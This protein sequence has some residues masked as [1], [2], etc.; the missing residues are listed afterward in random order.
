M[1]LKFVSGIFFL[2]I[3][4]MAVLAGNLVRER[5]AST[6]SLSH[7]PPASV[8]STKEA[9]KLPP[10]SSE[11]KPVQPV[12]A[13]KILPPSLS[14]PLVYGGDGT[15]GELSGAGIFN[16]TNK[17][18][19]KENLPPLGRNSLLDAA[20][21]IKMNDMF[22][23]GYFEHISP[24]GKGIIDLAK[25][26]GYRFV[27]VGENLALGDFGGDEQLVN[28]WMASPGHRENIMKPNFQE[29]GIAVGEGMY[30]GKKT[31]I[32]VQEFGRPISACPTLDE[33]L[34]NQIKAN[35]EQIAEWKKEA[36]A[37]RN[38]LEAMSEYNPLYYEKAK[39]YNELAKRINALIE[40]TEIL[41]LKYNAQVNIYN[42]CVAE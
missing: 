27:S 29:I 4:A 41:V 17:N 10:Q 20:A 35:N 12:I 40:E 13:K 31:W 14:N 15:N 39:Q 16:F 2:V 6:P 33:S 28:A 37:Y 25:G 8:S 34:S 7:I 21:I 22:T 30:N 24:D 36:E 11:P 32:A 26:V 18:R 23:R 1:F 38:E 42:A 3:I 19:A 5:S 9:S